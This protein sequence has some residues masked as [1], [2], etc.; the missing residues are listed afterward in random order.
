LG[1][2]RFIVFL[3]IYLGISALFKMESFKYV[4]DNVPLIFA[5]LKKKKAA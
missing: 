4:I 5:K 3:V 1:I 2:V